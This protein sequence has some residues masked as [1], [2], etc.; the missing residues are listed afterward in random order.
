MKKN[1]TQLK[2]KVKQFKEELGDEFKQQGNITHLTNKLVHFIDEFLLEL[3][4]FN[5]MQ[6]YKDCCLIAIG[7]YGRRELQLYSDIDILLLHPPQWDQEFEQS[8]QKFIQDGWDA[9]L[10]IK[11]QITT[12]AAYAELAREDLTALSSILDMRLIAG[13]S[14]LMEEL[15]YMTHPLNMW[16]SHAFFFA[17]IQEQNQRYKK[18]G[19]TAYNLEPNV[20]QGS[21]GLRDLQV[22]LSIGKRHFG[23]KKL[24]EGINCGFFTDKEYEEIIHCQHFLWRVR[25]GLHW[26]AGK[27]ED[28]LIFDYQ[29]KLAELFGFKDKQSSLAI[30]Q[31]MKSYYN[32]I[33]RSHE[34]NEILLQ[35]FDEAIIYQE[36]ISIRPLNQDFQLSN[37]Y[38]EIKHP[39]VFIEKPL[40]LITIFTWLGKENNIRGIRANT[41]RLIRENLYLLNNKL[42]SSPAARQ[43]FLSIFKQNL[44]P[45][46]ALQ[47]MNRY[48]VLSHYLDCFAKISGQ[49]QYD[50]YHV[51]TVDQHTLF[52]IRNLVRF[53]HEDYQ[54]Q[55]PLATKLMATIPQ[56]EIL[57]LAALF[58]DIAKGRGGDHSQ[59]GAEEAQAFAH[60]H[61]LVS[62]ES[63]LLVWLVEHHL[64]MS[65]TAQRQD[66]YSPQVISHFCAQIPEEYY[67]DYLYLLTVADICAT[68]PALWNAWK[69]ALL[70]E[71]YHA[72]KQ[73]F[74]QESLANEKTIIEERQQAA[75]AILL[76]QNIS[77]TAIQQLWQYFK[78]KFFLHEPADIIAYHTAAILNCTKFPL[79]QIM[80]HHSQ[81]GTKIFIYSPHRDDRVI[82]ATTI[83]NNYQATI[84][85]ATILTCDNQFD[86]DTYIVLNEQNQAMFD[87]QSCQVISKELR[88]FLANKNKV[89]NTIQ[90]RISLQQ[91]HFK[92]KTSITFQN[93][94][95]QNHTS[96]FL[97]TLDKPGLLA[98]VSRIFANNHLHLHNAKISTI[99]E[100]VEDMFYLSTEE[101]LLLT[102]VEKEQLQ[103][104]LLDCIDC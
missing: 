66:I 40:T 12:V 63:N 49:M 64:L 70:K 6:H 78:D 75:L 27:Q 31:F 90:K 101:G 50:L 73:A 44:N 35:W 94:V 60:K 22:L 61:H 46:E 38:I 15:R 57:Y 13:R 7:S 97:V 52:V 28:R 34:L 81:A 37:D 47:Y 26:L 103:K 48:G 8:A 85:E 98:T 100:R 5:R 88:H 87:E 74:Q 93:D 68:N 16:D 65:Q 23:I 54:K 82:I 1:N 59:L 56:K 91:A 2:T 95:Q 30:E 29:L 96:L 69:D 3:F 17:K 39:R 25:F 45:Y 20:K 53:R 19:E 86:L 76:Q 71:L 84:Q 89:P 36:K 55:F 41:I 99:G 14:A 4:T 77:E 33:K 72:A 104:N 9:G 11:Q 43:A 58:H 79:V 102:Q 32:N 18:Y 80:P 83:L 10:E 21:G 51:F 24:A 42:V 92:I 67:L 62:K